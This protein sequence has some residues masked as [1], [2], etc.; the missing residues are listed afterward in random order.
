MS[1]II[2]RTEYHLTR[3]FILFSGIT[4]KSICDCT[5]TVAVKKA[6]EILDI[7]I[8]DKEMIYYIQR[9]RDDHLD[10]NKHLKGKIGNDD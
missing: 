7:E 5:D 6:L 3:Q 2:D 1:K 9:F 10:F 8:N 4:Q